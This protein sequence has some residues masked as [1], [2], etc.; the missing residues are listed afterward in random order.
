MKKIAITIRV[1]ILLLG[2]VLMPCINATTLGKKK[3]VEP[4]EIVAVKENN[5]IGENENHEEPSCLVSVYGWVHVHC[6]PPPVDI[7]GV[8]LTL[9]GDYI[10]KTTFSGL[11][12]HYSFNFVQVG[13]QYTLTATH[14]KYKTVTKT[15]TLL[16]DEPNLMVSISMYEKDDSKARA[17]NQD[18]SCGGTIYGHTLESHDTWGAYPVPFALVDAGIKKTIS[19]P[20]SNYRITGLPLN[21]EITIT[22]SKKGYHSDTLKH[23]FTELKSTYYYCFDL[24][25]DEDDSIKEKNV[26][27]TTCL[28]SIYG[29]AGTSYGW[30]FS[31][32][33]FAKITARC[34][35]TYSSPIMG[36]YKISNLPLGT[37]TITGSKKGYD[38]FTDTIT[39]TEDRPDKQVFIHMEPND[40]SVNR[41]K[42]I[43]LSKNTRN[44]NSIDLP[45]LSDLVA[46]KISDKL[47]KTNSETVEQAI[48][49]EESTCFGAIFGKTSGSFEHASWILP[50]VKI[51][52]GGKTV[53]SGL[54]SRYILNGLELGYTYEIKAS[55][56]GYYNS[57]YHV[58]LTA[59]EPYKYQNIYLMPDEDY[60][61][62]ETTEKN[63][64]NSNGK[65]SGDVV[66]PGFSLFVGV[67]GIK[68]ACG[69]N[70]DE[71][72]TTVTDG[73]GEFEFTDL[74]Y[75][76]SGTVYRV[77]MQKIPGKIHVLKK[78]RVTLDSENPEA[79]I[80][81]IL[82]FVFFNREVENRPRTLGR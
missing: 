65:I 42:T 60:N 14:P 51:Q 53:S 39:L 34:R 41:E 26:V 4:V 22:A 77:W 24:K 82:P 31:P 64:I 21:Q 61:P 71:Y 12:G 80:R 38:T 66:A 57:T 54:G 78:K 23:T 49:N 44:T 30:G 10:T 67:P 11:F 59:E 40:E 19:G 81:F 32:V 48:N 58:E 25:E 16:A 70:Y 75:E 6:F 3:L 72:V 8:K 18:V 79:N 50:F 35:A 28:G 73:G 9:E 56:P 1:S 68:M 27:E 20:L 2:I 36:S 15:F 52:A 62:V 43:S 5:Q 37:Y 55:K 45:R 29:S 76:D 7:Q 63:T 47:E 17:I 13:R 69:K 46:E 74:P 33:F